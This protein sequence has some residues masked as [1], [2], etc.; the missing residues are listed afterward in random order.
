MGGASYIVFFYLVYLADL[1]IFFCTLIRV[2]PNEVSPGP[3]VRLCLWV[4]RGPTVGPGGPTVGL[5]LR[6]TRSPTV[7][8]FKNETDAT[9]VACQQPTLASG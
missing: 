8:Q 1:Q 3:P 5:R 2:Y 7:I 4:A 9:G 6:V